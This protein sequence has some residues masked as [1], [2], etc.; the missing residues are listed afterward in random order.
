MK[1]HGI[2][3]LLI[4]LILGVSNAGTAAKAVPVPNGDFEGGLEGWML[5]KP[6]DFAHG[7]AEIEKQE[8]HGGKQAVRIRNEATGEKVLVGL[9]NVQAIPLPDEWRHFRIVVWLK[10]EKAPEMIELRIASADRAGKL[11]TP[12]QEKGWRFIRPA[13]SPHIG[14]WAFFDAEFV[15]QPEWGGVFLTLWVR[16]AGADVLV[17]D[18]SIEA[19]NPQDWAVAQSGVRLPDPAPGVMLWSE[20]PLRKVYPDDAPPKQKGQQLQMSAAGD[21][22]DTLQLCLRADKEL[23]NVSVSFSDLQ[24]PGKLPASV[25]R[26]NLVGLIA[27]QKPTSGHALTGPTPDPLLPD[28]SFTIPG[29][30]TRSIWITL[31]VPRNTAA[32]D[33]KG[34]IVLQAAE[35]LRAVIPLSVHVYGFNLPER[36]TLR[37]IARIW[38]KH[39]GYESLFLKNLQ[40][41]RCSGTSYLGG[42]KT[43]RRNGNIIVDVSGLPE[44][45]EQRLRPYGFTVF[46]VPNI[47]LGDWSGLYNKEGKWM[48]LPVFTA[49]FDEAFR[50]YCR[51]VGAAL[52]QE[53]V[54]PYALWQVWDEPHDEWIAKA[55]HLARLVKE[56]V[57]DAQ[58][59]MTAGVCPELIELVDIWCL[60]W[61]NEYNAWAEQAR[62]RG[63]TL[64]AYENSL[65]SLDVADSSLLMRSYLWRLKRYD[66][67]GVEWWAVSQWRSDPWTEPNQYAPQNG[68]GFFLYPTPDRTGAPIDSLRWEMYREGVEDYDILT[69]LAESQDKA[70]QQL[71]VREERLLG[72]RQ[73]QELA[74]RVAH[75]EAKVTRD[76]LA[77]EQARKEACQRLELL[78]GPQP[79]ALGVQRDKQGRC[80]LVIAPGQASVKINGQRRTG[81]L[82]VFTGKPLQPIQLEV[83]RAG[84]TWRLKIP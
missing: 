78:Q 54:L 58:V 37:T 3:S 19:I 34:Q 27:V 13:L 49:E 75:S 67:K 43:E 79:V 9:A 1:L 18:I 44:A 21:E 77:T 80:T 61:P 12:W 26:A 8:V 50:S 2:I 52:R 62:A 24:G 81:R 40:D 11:L 74:A 48:G 22:Y 17:D 36:P 4:I 70:L 56:A 55:A 29:G 84:R 53:G 5:Y 73:A 71:G 47:F 6:A 15:A 10:A 69:L 63:A 14:Q 65:Y 25:L 82:I 31:H 23:K 66:I 20:G 76:P 35:G 30:Q 33:Y 32:G 59:Y 28:K 45:L 7:Q 41:H 46:N 60:P 51:Q 64:W 39:E 57:P 68:G 72:A 38:A 83:T 16:G 42:I